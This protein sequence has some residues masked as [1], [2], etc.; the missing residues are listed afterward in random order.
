[1]EEPV[2]ETPDAVEIPHRLH[3]LMCEVY[4][5]IVVFNL[6]SER[7]MRLNELIARLQRLGRYSKR[8]KNHIKEMLVELTGISF[9][10]RVAIENDMFI[11]KERL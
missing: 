3:N 1:M 5:I 2:V 9:L 8:S 10:F 7:S 6:G 11:I 4:T